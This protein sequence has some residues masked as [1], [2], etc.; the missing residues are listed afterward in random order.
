MEVIAKRGSRRSEPW[1]QSTA[2]PSS[3]GSQQDSTCPASAVIQT[4]D[5]YGEFETAAGLRWR[6]WTKR[7]YCAGPGVIS[8]RSIMGVSVNLPATVSWRRR[9]VAAPHRAAS[10]SSAT[11]ADQPRGWTGLAKELR[12]SRR[13]LRRGKR[14]RSTTSLLQTISGESNRKNSSR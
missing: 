14:A 9:G 2:S 7:D 13:T 1:R 11:L 3:N 10:P 6:W 12:S 8:P 4:R 5:P